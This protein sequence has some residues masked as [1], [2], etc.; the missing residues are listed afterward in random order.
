[1]DNNEK[2]EKEEK[3]AITVIVF[4]LRSKEIEDDSLIGKIERHVEI[5]L[6]L[7]GV[8]SEIGDNVMFSFPWDPSVTTADI[9]VFVVA[10]PFSKDN[11][12]IDDENIFSRRMKTALEVAFRAQ[13]EYDECE[14]YTIPEGRRVQAMTVK[15]SGFA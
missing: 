13:R 12:L 8:A 4:G 6:E 10:I 1:M 7:S 3:A 2:E 5:Q 11:D 14:G 15:A 9:P